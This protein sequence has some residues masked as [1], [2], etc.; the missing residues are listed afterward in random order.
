MSY[1]FTI[2]D[3]ESISRLLESRHEEFSRGWSWKLL[4][5]ERSQSLVFTIYND[6]RL[7]KNYT[8]SLVS[9]QTKHGYFEL[10]DC[11]SFIIFEPDEIIFTSSNNEKTNCLLISREGNC[12]L[13]CNIAKE[14]LST[15]FSEIDSPVLLSA[16][17]LSLTESL[18]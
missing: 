7:S 5:P 2:D 12:S 18:V 11:T 8:G 17:Q 13:F 1:I 16:M 15:D 9:V 4:N 6:V 14:I 3:I 10:H